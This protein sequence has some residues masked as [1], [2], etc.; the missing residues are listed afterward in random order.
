M[1]IP[2][3]N[4]HNDTR[5]QIFSSMPRTKFRF[6]FF[7]WKIGQKFIFWNKY[8]NAVKTRHDLCT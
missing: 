4:R 7:L 3:W 6:I 5:T 2:Q 8:F 1:A